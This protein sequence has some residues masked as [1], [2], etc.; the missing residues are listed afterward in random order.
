VW[1]HHRNI[2]DDIMR[3]CA[4]RGGVIGI[5]GIGLFLGNNDNRSE[6]V[7]NHIDHVVSLV[8]EDHVGIGLDYVFDAT[9]LSESAKTMPHL[10]A[11]Y[12]VS[13][14]IKLVAPEQIVEIVEI[15]LR[16]GYSG[17]V[18]GKILGGNFMRVAGQVWR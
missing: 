17:D 2:S 13:E 18:I 5:N 7:A 9:E 15:L 4:A 6:T 12:D 1:D 11:G 16:R 14:G 3:A 8:G 10:F